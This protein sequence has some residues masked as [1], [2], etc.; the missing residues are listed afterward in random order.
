MDNRIG[1]KL[2]GAICNFIREL[3]QIADEENY[4]RD[5]F[6]RAIADLF[7]GIAEISTFQEFQ[8]KRGESDG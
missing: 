7:S 6:V 5:S 3:I 1:E 4:D 2:N 8:I